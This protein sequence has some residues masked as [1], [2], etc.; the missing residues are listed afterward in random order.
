[1]SAVASP[2]P[3]STIDL[4]YEGPS[5]REARRWARGVLA[6]FVDGESVDAVLSCFSELVSNSQMHTSPSLD[7][8]EITCRLVIT[9]AGVVKV[10][11]EVI[12]AGSP[13]TAAVA[14]NFIRAGQAACLYSLRI[15]PRRWCRRMSR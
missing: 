5:A 1:V 6:G 9:M 15:P 4:P 2:L 13:A 7:R 11:G 10:R 14:E 12:D 3:V 8:K